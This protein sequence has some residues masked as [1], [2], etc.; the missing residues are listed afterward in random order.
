[1]YTLRK[2]ARPFF[3]ESDDERD[4]VN[5]NRENFDFSGLPGNASIDLELLGHCG[6]HFTVDVAD[7]DQ[8]IDERSHLAFC[9]I[10]GVFGS[11]NAL[12]IGFGTPNVFLMAPEQGKWQKFTAFMFWRQ[13]SYVANI[14][15]RMQVGVYFELRDLPDEAIAAIKWEMETQKGAR[16]ASCANA[17]AKVLDRAGFTCG[18]KSLRHVY[19]PSRLAA[20]IWEHGLEYQGKP[21]A[22]RFI[23]TSESI[24]SHFKAV[25]LKELTSF[26]RMVKKQ[27]ARHNTSA[28]AQAPKFDTIP[29]SRGMSVE[30]WQRGERTT[31]RISRPSWLGVWLSFMLGQ[32]PIFGADM[33]EMDAPELATPLQSFPG[34]LDRVT[35]LKKYILFSRPVIWLVR[36]HL[37]KTNDSH[38]NVP[39]RA[40]VEMLRRGQSSAPFKYNVVITGREVLITRLTNDHPLLS[41]ILS[42]HVMM[43]GYSPDVR[44]AGEV[45]RNEGDTF[46]SLNDNSGT[47][48]PDAGRLSA[49]AAHL[50]RAFELE[51]RPSPAL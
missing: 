44:F 15:D 49:A 4:F 7:V 14:A 19:R 2:A 42:K 40:A 9:P 46:V 10:Q 24:G 20:M 16:T 30:H 25:W 1:M 28:T 50:S 8:A 26:C 18:G 32:Y 33:P 48:K 29:S 36:R 5:A 3:L 12:F 21:V 45:W 31:V 27:F 23:R 35:K 38:Q 34:K 13:R 43:S 17:N 37:A 11:A 39:R 22:I 47:Y 41:W 6:S 51:V